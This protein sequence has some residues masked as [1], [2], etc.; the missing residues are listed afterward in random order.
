MIVGSTAHPKVDPKTR[1]RIALVPRDGSAVTRIDTAP[2]WVWHCANAFDTPGGEVVVTDVRWNRPEGL[3]AARRPTPDSGKV[4]V[5][6]PILM[7]GS[8][9]DY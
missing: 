9:N 5:G 4:W 6:E 2:F 8:H 3:A 7:S 1:T